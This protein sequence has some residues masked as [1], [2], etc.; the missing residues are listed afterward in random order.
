MQRTNEINLKLKNTN[1]KKYCLHDMIFVQGPLEK[2]IITQT[3][4]TKELDN[5]KPR[6]QNAHHTN[7]RHN[8]DRIEN[9]GL[10]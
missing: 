2:P 1:L 10:S 7:T 5:L 6:L 3:K 4:L 9:L 8:V